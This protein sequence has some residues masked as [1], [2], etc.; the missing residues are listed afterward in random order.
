MRRTFACG[1][2]FLVAGLFSTGCAWADSTLRIGARTGRFCQGGCAG[3]LALIGSRSAFD[4]AQEFAGSGIP[5]GIFAPAAG[6]IDYGGKLDGT[7]FTEADLVTN[8]RAI[9]PEPGSLALVGT[10]PL[11]MALILRRPAGKL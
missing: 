5:L 6:G 10:G 11:S 3:D 1:T 8:G 2:A 9:T 4:T 7:T